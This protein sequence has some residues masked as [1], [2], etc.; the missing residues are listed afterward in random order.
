MK[1]SPVFSMLV[2]TALS[3]AVLAQ[4]P[5]TASTPRHIIRPN[6]DC[7][8]VNQISNWHIVDDR[9]AT[10]S[11]GPKRFRVDLQAACPRLGLGPQGLLFTPNGSNSSL[12]SAVI[13]GEVGETVQSTRQ[14]P[15]GVQAVHRISDR[16]YKRL[17][18]KSRRGG[19]GA[20]QPTAS[21]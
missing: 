11:N 16:E 17:N 4:P 10:V 7:I 2:M 19:S 9:T 5:S 13:C 20:D 18:R 3:T 8:Q 21:P 1:I 14:P 6:F 12:G 15:C